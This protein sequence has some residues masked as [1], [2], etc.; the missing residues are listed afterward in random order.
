MQT[1]P[2][3]LRSIHPPVHR[4]AGIKGA[5][6]GFNLVELVVASVLLIVALVAIS[7]VF[8]TFSRNFTSS[9][10]RDGL[11]ALISRDL[12]NLRGRVAAYGS[13]TTTGGRVEYTPSTSICATATLAEDMVTA[14]TGTFPANSTIT[15][16][17]QLRSVVVNR[18]ITATGNRLQVSYATANGS[19]I[20][21]NLQATLV[22]P[23]QSWCP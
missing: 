21:L 9:R 17:A 4:R 1:L 6:E 15:A 8:T 19:P 2:S 14:N 12:E 16:P 10:L 23:A 20:S 7:D 18:T 22:P 5:N 11:S 13:P 3:I